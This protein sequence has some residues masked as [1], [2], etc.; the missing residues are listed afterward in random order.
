MQNYFQM[1]IRA[2]ELSNMFFREG[3]LTYSRSLHIFEEYLESMGY[4]ITFRE[5]LSIAGK[6]RVND[7]VPAKKKSVAFIV[8]Y[9]K[10]SL[11]VDSS[12]TTQERKFLYGYIIAGVSMEKEGCEQVGSSFFLHLNETCFQQLLG[13]YIC[14]PHGKI[15]ECLVHE[16]T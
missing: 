5:D 9:D 16:K 13:T 3:S 2:R 11:T 7:S 14:I 12:L 10:P 8:D 15:L 6:K 1:H 4:S